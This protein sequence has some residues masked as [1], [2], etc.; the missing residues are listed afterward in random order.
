MAYI[1][2]LSEQAQKDID[3][4]KISGNKGVLKKLSVLLNELTQHPSEG[5]GKPEQLKHNLAGYWSRRINQEHRLIYRID[6]FVVK[7]VS[8]REHYV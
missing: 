2:D 6:N 5:T 4:H 3:F 8:A 1:L 7:I